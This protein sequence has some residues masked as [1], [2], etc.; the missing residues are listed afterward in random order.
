MF[1]SP[2]AQSVLYAVITKSVGSGFRVKDDWKA[3]TPVRLKTLKRE[4]V[5]LGLTTVFTTGIQHL[6]TKTL[7][8]ALRKNPR[9]AGFELIL[10][11][12]LTAPALVVAEIVSRKMAP[13]PTWDTHLLQPAP[14]AGRANNPFAQAQQPGKM[15]SE[16]R[17]AAVMVAGTRHQYVG[18]PK[19]AHLPPL[20]PV[21]PAGSSV[22]RM[23]SFR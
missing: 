4:A 11:T 21:A 9:L 22:S 18:N 7:T 6:F 1:L 13:K 5:L 12:L 19:A 23:G 20:V 15:P 17:Q 8:G 16:A 2:T 14:Q 10:R 3:P